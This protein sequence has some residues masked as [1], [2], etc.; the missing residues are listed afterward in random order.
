MQIRVR[1]VAIKHLQLLMSCLRHD[2]VIKGTGLSSTSHEAGAVIVPR[3]VFGR[4]AP[5]RA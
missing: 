1:D 3:K 2:M 5:R 4:E